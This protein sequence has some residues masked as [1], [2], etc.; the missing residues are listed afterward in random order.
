[1]PGPVRRRGKHL[2]EAHC[3][4]LVHLSYIDASVTRLLELL[5]KTGKSEFPD[6]KEGQEEAHDLPEH[7]KILR[8]AGSEGVPSPVIS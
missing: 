1:M 8:R 6:W 5:Y 7:R 2:I 3:Q 4:G